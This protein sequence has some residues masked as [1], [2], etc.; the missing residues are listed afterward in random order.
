MENNISL[1]DKLQN[2]L[3]F[4]KKSLELDLLIQ[5]NNL[6][7]AL[8]LAQKLGLNLQNDLRV[9]NFKNFF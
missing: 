7:E 9:L 4:L 5:S 8:F 2:Y 6:S 3:E 1:S